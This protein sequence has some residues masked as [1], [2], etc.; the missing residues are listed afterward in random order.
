[1]GGGRGK[2][3][4]PGADGA[5]RRAEVG[6][7]FAGVRVLVVGD[8]MLDRYVQGAVSRV[9][10]EAPVPVVRVEREWASPGGAG[11]VAASL[12][13]LGCRGALARPGG[14]RAG[15]GEVG[16]ALRAAGGGPSPG[17]AARGRAPTQH[18]P[19]ARGLLPLERI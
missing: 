3:W 6:D 4:I 14:A 17:R 15:P 1:G 11:H 2:R 7:G 8:V 16:R 12:A 9:S 10:P 5:A 13:G 18:P 19:P